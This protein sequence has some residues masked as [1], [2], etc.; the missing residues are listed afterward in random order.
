[1]KGFSLE[2]Q[3]R[4]TKVSKLMRGKLQYN[5]IFICHI[6]HLQMEKRKMKKIDERK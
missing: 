4:K 3:E 2:P 6:R 5:T 1:M